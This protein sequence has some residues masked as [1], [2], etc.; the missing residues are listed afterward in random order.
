MKIY[1]ELDFASFEP[2]SGAVDTHKRICDAGK[3]ETFEAMLKD[4]YPDGMSKTDLNDLL[5]FEHE[6]CYQLVGLRMESEIKEE[7][8]AAQEELED[9]K[10][11]FEDEI[12][13]RV[14]CINSDRETRDESELTQEEIEEMR[15]EV[16]AI[17]FEAD[18]NEIKARINDLEEELENI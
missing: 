4:C 1:S 18:A 13:K 10:Q 8:E 16:W 14:D 2:W 7:I 9:L 3:A 6:W 12:E 15:S 5:W 17:D 11:E